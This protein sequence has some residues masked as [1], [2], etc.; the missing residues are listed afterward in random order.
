MNHNTVRPHSKYE[1]ISVAD[2]VRSFDA[3][4]L[5]LKPVYQ[6]DSTW[7]AI[8]KRNFLFSLVSDRSYF[9]APVAFDIH[10]EHVEGRS[11]PIQIYDVLDGKQRLTTIIGFVKGQNWHDAKGFVKPAVKST[12]PRIGTREQ[13]NPL[14]QVHSQAM[15]DYYGR[16][17]AELDPYSQDAFM[18]LKISAFNLENYEE[19]II[20]SF[21]NVMNISKP[22]TGGQKVVALGGILTQTATHLKDDFPNVVS[23]FTSGPDKSGLVL[24]M[25]ISLLLQAYQPDIIFQRVSI[26][27]LVARI[28]SSNADLAL[29]GIRV[30]L[31]LDFLTD[32]GDQAANY[33]KADVKRIFSKGRITS[34]F[35]FWSQYHKTERKIS[36]K[37]VYFALHKLLNSKLGEKSVEF[38]LKSGQRWARHDH[39]IHLA[40]LIESSLSTKS[41]NLEPATA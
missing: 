30:R 11:N 18:N 7:D 19:D 3:G 35:E 40:K 25:F 16:T 23:L 13:Y 41:E 22:L 28:K 20:P 21:F 29:E 15:D 5:N 27:N 6:R 4:I 31:F 39:R 17:F 38:N 34:L 26:E 37:T 1:P 8:Y 9:I 33:N 10:F 14:T 24:D 32:L 36:P 2:L 12:T